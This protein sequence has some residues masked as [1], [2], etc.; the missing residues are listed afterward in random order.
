MFIEEPEVEYT[1]TG[2]WRFY[3][4]ALLHAGGVDH[5]FDVLRYDSAHLLRQADVDDLLKSAGDSM[6]HVTKRFTLLICR[7]DEK[8]VTKP[9]WTYQRLLKDQ[10]IEEIKDPMK[11]YDY[12]PGFTGFHAKPALKWQG[13]CDVTGNLAYVLNTMLLNR[14]MPE[15]EGDAH[16]IEQAFYHPEQEIT[17]KLTSYRANKDKWSF[18]PKPKV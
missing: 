18:P 9:G 15:N 3:N 1:Q 12:M 13:R 4:Y 10:E 14:A 6:E 17:V 5:V 7:R 8:G 16:K 2:P 11:L